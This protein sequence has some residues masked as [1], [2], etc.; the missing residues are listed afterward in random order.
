L[1]FILK[2]TCFIILIFLLFNLSYICIAEDIS[3]SAFVDENV[4]Q[5]G[6]VLTLTVRINGSQ[7]VAA[8]DLQDI[9]G[10]QGRYVGPSTRISIVNNKST[11]FIDHRYYLT[12]MKVGQFTIPSMT[13]EHSG[14]TYKTDPIKVQVVPRSGRQ[15]GKSMTPEDIKRYIRLIVRTRNTTAYLNEGV[16]LLI[17]LYIKSGVEVRDIRYPSFPSEGFSVLPFSEPVQRQTTMEGVSYRVIDFT[18]TVYPVT[19]GELELGPA[20]LDCNLIIS[21]SNARDPFLDFFDRRMRYQLTVKS[22]PYKINV[23]PIPVEGQPDSFSG[24]VGQYEMEV[25]AKPDNVKVGEPVTLTMIIKGAGNIDMVNMPKI[26]NLTRFKVYDP[27][28]NVEKNGNY[29]EKTFEQVLIPTSDEIIQIPEIR[30]SYFDPDSES[31]K[32][33]RK[34][35]IPVQ[36]TPSESAEPIQILE[37]AEGRAVKKEVL[38]RDIV[39]IKDEVGT[40]NFGGGHLY[41]NKGFLILQ[42]LPLIGFLGVVI[43]QRRR[44]KFANDKSYA[45]QY[46]A[47][48]K[49]K[50]GLAKAQGLA[51]SGLTQE[52]C[53]VIFKTM[54]EYLGDRFDLPVAGITVDVVGDLRER[55]ISEEI[56]EKITAFFGSC[57]RAR[58]TQSRADEREMKDMLNLAGEIIQALENTK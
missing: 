31:Y 9:E 48:K 57:D 12:A 47:P 18:T 6:G 53:S 22:D 14:N 54:Q 11:V 49:A 5:L 16:P 41:N 1:E 4:V 51:E 39:Y 15:Q 23:K 38:G 52:F 34:G 32:T 46:N 7:S 42:L 25:T 19:R 43:Y 8:P 35:P 58:F 26:T 36:V 2:F 27:Q 37:L 13:V 20:E 17:R 56:L 21:G 24:A 40:V 28:T 50:K 30:F 3:V 29:G 33:L 44:E 55:G 45:R 10:F